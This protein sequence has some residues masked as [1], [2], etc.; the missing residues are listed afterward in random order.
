MN[1]RY[2]ENTKKIVAFVSALS[3]LVGMVPHGSIFEP[4][5]AEAASCS[6]LSCAE[7]GPDGKSYRVNVTGGGPSYTISVMKDRKIIGQQSV[8]SSNGIWKLSS[9]YFSGNNLV[10]NWSNNGGTSDSTIFNNIVL[11]DDNEPPILK[12][13]SSKVSLADGSVTIN[14][15]ATDN[16]GVTSLQIAPGSRS[17]YDFYKIY[18]LGTSRTYVV[19]SNGWYTVIAKDAVGNTTY[20]DIHITNSRSW[21]NPGLVNGQ[22]QSV[23]LGG[24]VPGPDALYNVA[25]VQGT[26][27]LMVQRSGGANFQKMHI[28][29]FLSIDR[30]YFHNNDLVVVYRSNSSEILN[31]TFKNIAGSEDSTEP[32]MQM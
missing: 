17:N 12:L 10:V 8:Y 3:L 20:Q 13:T 6:G 30:M 25:Y 28:S 4:I 29:N 21:V 5:K 1:R 32:T 9:V 11:P 16:M 7:I 2:N 14:I 23:A 15:D 24:N 22:V 27:E 18:N 26:G 31:V 19:Q